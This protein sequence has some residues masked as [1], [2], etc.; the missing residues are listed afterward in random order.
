[1]RPQRLALF[2]APL[3]RGLPLLTKKDFHVGVLIRLGVAYLPV[4]LAGGADDQPVPLLLRE[5][6]LEQ[7]RHD[8]GA[9]ARVTPVADH[10][11]LRARVVRVRGVYDACVT[12]DEDELVRILRRAVSADDLLRRRLC[13]LSI[14]KLPVGKLFE[15]GSLETPRR[16]P[17]AP[18][19][20]GVLISLVLELLVE[21]LASLLLRLVEVAV[22]E[23]HDQQH[24]QQRDDEVCARAVLVAV[25]REV[26]LQSSHNT[27][28]RSPQAVG[29]GGERLP[30]SAPEAVS[31]LLTR[32]PPA[33]RRDVARQL[34][35]VP[36]ERVAR[37]GLEP[38]DAL[39]QLR[40]DLPH[41][42]RVGLRLLLHLRVEPAD[43]LRNL[44][45]LLEQRLV[46]RPERAG[47]LPH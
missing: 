19:L 2:C 24:R 42:P 7:A 8:G 10:A 3:D 25:F 12:V 35:H 38:A 26:V 13:P 11:R 21:L 32:E 16:R 20:R 33:E 28:R 14:S 37:P 1:M 23:D 4:E 36:R 43:V 30:H 41:D 34:L 27:P 9:P 45:R 5:Q 40:P 39:A 22:D 29:E 18:A 17:E 46:Q 47:E 15:V 6:F 31:V 44:L